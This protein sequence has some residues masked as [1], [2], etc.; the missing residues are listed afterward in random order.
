MAM[1]AMLPR[2]LVVV[3]LSLFVS[4]CVVGFVPLLG[5]PLVIEPCWNRSVPLLLVPDCTTVLLV[6]V[7]LLVIAAVPLVAR[8]Q[9]PGRRHRRN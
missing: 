4:V 7:R 5:V 3:L 6:C 9:H 2:L 8:C 1:A